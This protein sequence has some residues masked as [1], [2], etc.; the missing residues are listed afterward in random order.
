MG[1]L[2]GNVRRQALEEA[3]IGSVRCAGTSSIRVIPAVAV[4]V[5]MPAACASSHRRSMQHPACL[6]SV[7]QS[8]TAAL[9]ARPPPAVLNRTLPKC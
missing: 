6:P 8:E 4:A 1:W 9:T 2:A 5:E 3:M 7:P